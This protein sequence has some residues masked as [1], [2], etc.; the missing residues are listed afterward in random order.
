[1]ICPYC[2]PPCDTQEKARLR[3]GWGNES[4]ADVYGYGFDNGVAW[5]RSEVLTLLKTFSPSQGRK[6]EMCGVDFASWI[7]SHW[8]KEP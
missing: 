3:H 4:L 5:S 2:E 7:E 6:P 8:I 1:M